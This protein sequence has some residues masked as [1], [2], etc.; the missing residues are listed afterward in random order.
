M[1]IGQVIKNRFKSNQF[2]DVT[3]VAVEVPSKDSGR[4]EK[5]MAWA[6]R[7]EDDG[8]TVVNGH[9]ASRAGTAS[10]S[11]PPRM[12]STGERGLTDYRTDMDLK[13]TQMEVSFSTS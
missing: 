5:D 11:R 6:L 13:R 9:K 2:D 7:H 3:F 1:L 8:Y 4:T 12:P 10:A